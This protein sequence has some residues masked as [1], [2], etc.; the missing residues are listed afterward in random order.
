MFL[1]GYPPP[2]WLSQQGGDFLIIIMTPYF[3]FEQ[4]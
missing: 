1:A 2:Y 4:S 3:Y